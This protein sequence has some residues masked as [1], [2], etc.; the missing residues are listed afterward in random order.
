MEKT[1][2]DPRDP[3]ARPDEQVETPAIEPTTE[4]T[5]QADK[6]VH[7]ADSADTPPVESAPSQPETDTSSVESQVPPVTSSSEPDPEPMPSAKA[8]I[9]VVPSSSANGSNNGSG[10][11]GLYVGLLALV[12]A[13]GAAVFV[14]W[15]W[16]QEQELRQDNAL[17]LGQLQELKQ[18]M[19]QRSDTLERRIERGESAQSDHQM[20]LVSLREQQLEAQRRAAQRQPSDWMLAE[21]DYLVRMASRKLWLEHDPDTALALLKDADNRLQTLGQDDLLPLRQALA[22][23]MASLSALPR[24]DR[25][26]LSLGIESL[27]KRIDTL[28]L[29]TVTLP[30]AVESPERGEPSTTVSDWRTNLAKSWHALTDDFITVRRRQGAVQPLLAPE[31]EWYLREHLKGKLMQAQLALYQ[32][33]TDAFKE[34]LSTARLWISDYFNLDDSA[35]QGALAQLDQW[36][37]TQIGLTTPIRFTVA[38]PLAKLVSERLG[39]REGVAQ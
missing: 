22:D 2:K 11:G 7:T 5:S 25:A 9:P 24:L 1:P 14:G 15:Q 31:Q 20:A 27:I 29:N 28:P 8:E 26:G 6:P 35:V 17:L 4:S 33:H 37:D 13:I 3:Q 38:D 21:A 18:A 36:S 32:G 19:A 34:A 39:R 30:E 12:V 10:N 16:Q 23:D